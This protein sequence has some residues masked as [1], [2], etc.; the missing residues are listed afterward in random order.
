MTSQLCALCFRRFPLN[1]R[2]DCRPIPSVRLAESI[3]I[4]VSKETLHLEQA[5]KPIWKETARMDDVIAATL[6]STN[7]GRFMSTERCFVKPRQSN[8][9]NVGMEDDIQPFKCESRRLDVILFLRYIKKTYE[10]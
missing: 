10:L 4:N 2:S 7:T 1:T 5:N 9:V 8:A 3:V 6:I